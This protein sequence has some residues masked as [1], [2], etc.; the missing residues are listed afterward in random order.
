MTDPNPWPIAM[1]V[2]AARPSAPAKDIGS[3][4][5][6][7]SARFAYLQAALSTQFDSMV[8]VDDGTST[9]YRARSRTRDW[10]VK[11]R[12]VGAVRR[13]V[14]AAM[15]QIRAPAIVPMQSSELLPDG[16]AILVMDPIP[17]RSLQDEMVASGG[18]IPEAAAWHWMKQLC[19]GMTYVAARRIVHR[20][21]KPANIVI[22]DTGL[23][24]V[25]D[26]DLATFA[27]SQE[28]GLAGTPIY[29][30]PEQWSQSPTSS[31][32]SDIYSFGAT[33]CHALTGTAPPSA[34]LGQRQPLPPLPSHVSNE[35]AQ[36]LERCLAP[37]P[38]Q[39]FQSFVELL[40]QLE[41]PTKRIQLDE[42]P[43]NVPGYHLLSCLG[44]GGMGVVFKARSLNTDRKVALKFM[45]FLGRDNLELL[46]RFRIEAEAVA[47][48]R[49][50][51]I[52]PVVEVGAFGGFPY[53][54]L[55]YVD[56]G[57]LHDRLGEF[58]NDAARI[59][60][61]VAAVAR[62]LHHAHRLGML[63]RD[64]KPQN[65]LLTREGTPKITDFGL[66]KFTID[67]A[68]RDRLRQASILPGIQGSLMTLDRFIQDGAWQQRVGEVARRALNECDPQLQDTI[69][70][71]AV[72]QFVTDTVQNAESQDARFLDFAPTRT[73]DILGTPAYM[74]P[75]QIAGS[76]TSLGPATDVYSLGVV[77]YQLLFGQLPFRARSI[78]E[79]FDQ[80][81]R[82]PPA[83]PD[84]NQPQELVAVC[85][86]CLSKKPE[87]RYA[88]AAELADHVER[89]Y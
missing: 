28:E 38:H 49:H 14:V 64:L 34:H 89:H 78:T 58:R 35:M 3:D 10:V 20:N 40:T 16:S 22:D 37:I 66:A 75:E 15:K 26:F 76:A 6:D 71:D 31:I 39:R 18:C 51:N 48:L 27:G 7:H 2:A 33:F 1:R 53:L 86:R 68:S 59:A 25:I 4:V 5:P 8:P 45:R 23:A 55:E 41:N 9:A 56:G 57:S 61:L 32:C 81:R 85:L 73:G 82:S 70:L 36:V 13:D 50:P 72:R 46:A 88:S 80:I 47:C 62:G 11:L 74:A 63:H 83:I 43:P 67:G 52:V 30:A 42:P 12:D 44:E 79:L 65:I 69:S 19:E 54:A 17:G 29:M 84:K 77:L 87:E 24:H 60:E 21:L